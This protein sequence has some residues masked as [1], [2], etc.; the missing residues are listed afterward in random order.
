MV[1]ILSILILSVRNSGWAFF[2]QWT[3]SI[4]RDEC[5]RQ[6]LKTWRKWVLISSKLKLNFE[7]STWTVVIRTRFPCLGLLDFLRNL[8]LR[9]KSEISVKYGQ[10][11]YHLERSNFKSDMMQSIQILGF[12][13]CLYSSWCFFLQ[14][15]KDFNMYRILTPEC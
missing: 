5:C 13:V 1:S 11:C 14:I 4:K 10:W 2:A 15:K 7:S 9:K 3:K 12:K 8:F 6:S